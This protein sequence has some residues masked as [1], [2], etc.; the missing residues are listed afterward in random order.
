MTKE[1]LKRA[2]EKFNN[3]CHDLE[4]LKKDSEWIKYN[5]SYET[6]IE[7]LIEYIDDIFN[8]IDKYLNSNLDNNRKEIDY[9]LILCVC[10]LCQKIS[11]YKLESYYDKLISLLKKINYDEYIMFSQDYSFDGRGHYIVQ[12]IL[13]DKENKNFRYE[14]NGLENILYHKYQF[15]TNER[16]FGLLAVLYKNNKLNLFNELLNLCCDLISNCGARALTRDLYNYANNIKDENVINKVIK[17]IKEYKNNFYLYRGIYEPKELID[18][19]IDK[20]KEL[21]WLRRN[22][23]ILLEDD[24]NKAYSNEL[25]NYY[26]DYYKIDKKILSEWENDIIEY[27]ENILN[28]VDDY[29]KLDTSFIDMN[30]HSKY[31]VEYL[32]EKKNYGKLLYSIL[33]KALRYKKL[34]QNRELINKNMAILYNNKNFYNGCYNEEF[35]LRLISKEL[36]GGLLVEYSM[37]DKD[38]FELYKKIVIDIIKRYDGNTYNPYDYFNNFIVRVLL[39]AQSVNDKDLITLSQTYLDKIHY[40]KGATLETAENGMRFSQLK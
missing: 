29:L 11:D 5:V 9:H 7:W 4:Y 38:L 36:D 25:I 10:I 19:H 23:Y 20:E 13:R 18:I 2:K 8:Q 27:Y 33:N 32:K 17:S 16:F 39:F 26:L 21:I 6:V 14:Y 37:L 22:F 34:Y 15:D 40:E 31:Y 24:K 3:A 12:Y 30:K 1:E 28:N 35:L